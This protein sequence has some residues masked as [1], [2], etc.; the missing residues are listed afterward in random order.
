[1]ANERN[2]HAVSRALN[3]PRAQPEPVG[4]NGW[5]KNEGRLYE[6]RDVD[7]NDSD[8]II[9]MMVMIIIM[10]IIPQL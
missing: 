7:D 8:K 3:T 9:I 4:Q 5:R 2:I 6:Y 10:N 1:M